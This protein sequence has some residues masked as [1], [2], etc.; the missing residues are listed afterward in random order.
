MLIHT[1]LEL[2]DIPRAIQ[3]FML[4]L[5]QGTLKWRKIK[6]GN[7]SPKWTSAN[8]WKVRKLPLTWVW[9]EALYRH[10]HRNRQEQ[11]KL[12][13]Q[14]SPHVVNWIFHQKIYGGIYDNHT[15]GLKI[16]MKRNT[17]K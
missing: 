6:I 8:Y 15:S 10:S 11:H 14:V 7:P 13:K 16:A 2:L 1:S 17:I 12:K 3:S 5:A 4:S 9:S